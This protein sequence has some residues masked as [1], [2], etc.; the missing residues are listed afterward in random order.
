MADEI[1]EPAIMS[2]ILEKPTT[3]RE[4]VWPDNTTPLV[5]ISCITYNHEK[6]IRDAIEGF[7]NQKT[8]F[9]VEILI[10][11]DASTDKTADII[12]EYELQYPTLIKPIYQTENRYSQGKRVGSYNRKRAIGSY[13][14]ICEGDDY[15]TDP[16]KL[17]K[18]IEI[19]QSNSELSMCMT[20]A[21]RIYED[22]QLPTT[23]IR[24]NDSD[25]LYFLKDILSGNP[26]HTATVV[27]RKKNLENIPKN[28]LFSFNFDYVMWVEL[29]RTGPIYYLNDITSVYRVHSGG[30]YSSL[31]QVDQIKSS[32][33][34][35]Y[36]ILE[37]IEPEYKVYL[38]RNIYSMNNRLINLYIENNDIHGVAKT[39]S[40]NL[41]LLQYLPEKNFIAK[42]STF[43]KSKYNYFIFRNLYKGFK[44]LFRG[45]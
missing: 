41:S 14:A 12:R 37:N 30:I 32:L 29:A 31:N 24:A 45:K 39:A 23:V 40:E 44:Y 18:Q 15:W 35:R 19:L 4:Q 9:P 21:K 10:H 2:K 42:I 11:D 20:A 17:E 28:L 36:T 5:S 13:I 26:V 3:L 34:T 38:Y 22:K 1:L 6:F 16:L 8:T 27:F 7:I 25:K 33:K 43:L